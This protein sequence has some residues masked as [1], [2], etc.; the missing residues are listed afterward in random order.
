M[1]TNLL[2]SPFTKITT[3]ALAAVL[4]FGGAY[5]KGRSDGTALTEAAVAADKLK[6]E[7]QVIEARNELDIKTDQITAEYNKK[8]AI[9]RAEIN[10]LT[11]SIAVGPSIVQTY[12][13]Q[14]VDTNVPNGFVELH[15]RAAAGSTL[16]PAPKSN[17]GELSNKS[18]VLV[19][20]T[21]VENYYSC[22]QYISQ[23][24]ALQEVVKTFQ[25]KQR[26]LVK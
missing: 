1:F 3:A 7:Q 14:K 4:L 25:N 2:F 5:L 21:V 20:S 8:T 23:L 26:E 16:D 9:Y 10:K 15:N 6:W 12:I 11:K 24:E 19:T 18:L 13:P 17:A 22:N